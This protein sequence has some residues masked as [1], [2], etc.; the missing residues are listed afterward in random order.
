M[1]DEQQIAALREEIRW[2]GR[3]LVRPMDRLATVFA[4]GLTGVAVV[5]L[6]G[7]VGVVAAAVTLLAFGGLVLVATPLEA[8]RRRRYHGA[9]RRR[10]DELAEEDRVAVLLPLRGDEL[11][12]EIVGPLLQEL[13]LPAELTPATVPTARGDEPSPAEKAR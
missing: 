6:A 1:R 8:L 2:A 10:L 5:V 11:A 3:R 7:V 12:E 9:F 13:R 4:L